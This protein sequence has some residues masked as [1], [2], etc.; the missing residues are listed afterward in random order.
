MLANGQCFQDLGADYYARLN[1]EALKARALQQLRQLGYEIT[2]TS[3]INPE[4]G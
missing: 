3:S 4:A 2:L 1:P